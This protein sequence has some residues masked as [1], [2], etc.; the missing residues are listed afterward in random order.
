MIAVTE[1]VFVSSTL[2]E[3]LV[4]FIPRVLASRLF[5]K[6]EDSIY[7]DDSEGLYHSL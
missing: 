3:S 1:W 4:F 6:T 5:R 2:P 7:R